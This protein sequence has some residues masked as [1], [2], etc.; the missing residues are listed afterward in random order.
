MMR[1]FAFITFCLLYSFSAISQADTDADRVFQF[2]IEVAKIQRK[3]KTLPLVD[4][5]DPNKT[6]HLDASF[7]QLQTYINAMTDST[8]TMSQQMKTNYQILYQHYQNSRKKAQQ[9]WQQYQAYKAKNH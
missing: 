6:K 9:A 1:I 7:A 8:D 5:L 2:Q 3:F 4:L